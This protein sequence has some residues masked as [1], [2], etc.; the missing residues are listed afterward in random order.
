[1]SSSRPCDPGRFF[2]RILAAFALFLGLAGCG[3]SGGGG[4]SGSGSNVSLLT[5]KAAL[6]HA[7]GA[8]DVAPSSL[9]QMA[10]G[11]VLLVDGVSGS[12][13]AI[14]S[15]GTVL[16]FTSKQDLLSLTGQL[17]VTLG[18]LD[19]STSGAL[20]GQ[21]LAADGTSGNLIRITS[22]GTP[23]LFSTLAA[24]KNV[25]GQASAQ[26]SLPREL[27]TNQVVAQD[28]VTLGILRFDPAGNPTLF[29]DGASLATGAGVALQLAAVA[30]WAR[31]PVSQSLF[32]RFASTSNI[33][34]IQING[35]VT[36]HVSSATLAAAFPDVSSLTVL[37]MVADPVTDSLLLLIGEGS[38]GVA[39]ALVSPSGGVSVS[40]SKAAM[41]QGAG[42]AVDISELF[43]LLGTQ[44][45][46]GVD[47]GKPQLLVFGSGGRVAAF[48]R[49]GDIATASGQADPS[50]TMGVSFAP[51]AV[52]VFE[53]K[54]ASLL[55][56][57]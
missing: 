16:L 10:N 46:F 45:V 23:N 52:L 53:A 38:K 9:F 28:L 1:M 43:L 50:V 35:T 41:K 3:G 32:A 26:M 15:D 36:R 39:L 7:T 30:G 20:S 57:N 54:S 14:N 6:T 19:Q 18:P 49:R 33:V 44:T 11:I 12:V 17:K 40:I 55:S 51:G 8:A 56:A 4:S 48:A 2:Q 31:G 25:T 22:L 24:I 47:R 29:V 27:T 42:D 21:L 34:R 5:S 13:A 37:D